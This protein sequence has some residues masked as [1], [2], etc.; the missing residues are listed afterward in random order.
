MRVNLKKSFVN[1][2]KYCIWFSLSPN[3]FLVTYKSKMLFSLWELLWSELLVLVLLHNYTYILYYYYIISSPST[4][5][6]YT[7]WHTHDL[8]YTRMYLHTA[9]NLETQKNEGKSGIS[10]FFKIDWCKCSSLKVNR[11]NKTLELVL[12]GAL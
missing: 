3:F 11:F 1:I 9:G 4:P 6:I 2:W 8:M 12:T 7:A 10:W 5:Q